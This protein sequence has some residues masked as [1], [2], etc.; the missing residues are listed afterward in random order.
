MD[1][2]RKING[3]KYFLDIS[4]SRSNQIEVMRLHKFL[5]ILFNELEPEQLNLEEMVKKEFINGGEPIEKLV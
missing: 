5:K 1:T 2:K 3:F 4:P